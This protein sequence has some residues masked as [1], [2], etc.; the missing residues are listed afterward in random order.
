[1]HAP[2]QGVALAC[3]TEAACAADRSASLG[4]LYVQASVPVY[5]YG[6]VESDTAK[7]L[8]REHN[9]IILRWLGG[10]NPP[11]NAML[12][13]STLDNER[14]ARSVCLCAANRER[15]MLVALQAVWCCMSGLAGGRA[16]SGP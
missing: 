3:V 7:L 12:V 11:L 5:R 15:P 6:M 10:A 4:R 9:K 16:H 14:C 8:R 1:M 13:K 2:A